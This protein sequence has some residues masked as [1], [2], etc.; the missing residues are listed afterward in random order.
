[1]ILEVHSGDNEGKTIQ[2]NGI[3]PNDIGIPSILNLIGLDE[4]GLAVVVDPGKGVVSFFCNL[5]IKMAI[6]YI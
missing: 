2:I 6:D 3:E 4:V 1:M 5:I